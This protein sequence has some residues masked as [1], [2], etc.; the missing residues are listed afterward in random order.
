[1]KRVRMLA[2]VGSTAEIT[3]LLKLAGPLVS[4]LCLNVL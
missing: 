3:Q 1:M 4:S 2:P